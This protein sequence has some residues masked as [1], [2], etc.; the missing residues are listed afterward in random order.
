MFSAVEKDV[1]RDPVKIGIGTEEQATTL[2]VAGADKVFDLSDLKFFL[3][4]PGHLVRDGDTLL[5][6]QPNLIKKSDMRVILSVSGSEGKG[7]VMCQ[8]PGHKAAPC[9]TDAKL[10][11]FRQL[12]PQDVSIPMAH[13][14]GRPG[15]I[16]YTLK[17]ADAII[18]AWHQPRPNKLSLVEVTREA[19]RLLDLD[20]GALKKH[21]VRD[22]V[23]KFV[24][25]AQR[26]KPDHWH[27]ISTETDKEPS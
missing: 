4:H 26:D 1:I 8:V 16:E 6:V 13:K 20:E 27:G 25:T 17:Q 24:G 22:L 21:W 7:G 23:K 10:S 5:M 14:L 12:K 11:A 9:D 2:K 15:K 19:E 18:R 3:K